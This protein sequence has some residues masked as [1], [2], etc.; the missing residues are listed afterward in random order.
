VG[1][2]QDGIVEISGAGTVRAADEAALLR[3]QA[4]AGR[5]RVLPAPSECV[6]L[7]SET[8]RACLLSGE[9]RSPGTFCD[10]LSFLGQMGW[11]GELVLEERGA[12]RSLYF[13]EGTVVAARST[14]LSE[15]LGEVLYRYGVLS[16]EQVTQCG[17]AVVEGVTRFGEAAVKLGCATRETLFGAMGRQTEEIFYGA[18]RTSEGMFFFLDGFEDADL[19]ARQRLDVAGIIREGIRRMHET[20]YFRARIPTSKHV[21][22]RIAGR[23][24]AADPMRLYA[25]IDDKR[26]VEEL[27][28]AIGAGDF[29][30][31]RALFQLVQSGCIVIKPPQLATRDVIAVY[32]RAIALI[33]RELDALDDG[34]SVRAELAKFVRES[35]VYELLFEGAGPADDGTL[36][37]SRVATNVAGAA[38]AENRLATWLYEYASYALFVARP[39]MQRIEQASGG[40][41]PR[42][43]ARVTAILE[44]IAPPAEPP[45][46]SRGG[47]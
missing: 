47:P 18:M 9:I 23:A 34:D 38:D 1:A 10:V 3:L 12:S 7:R 6:I 24:P 43:S 20:R 17:E 5:Y 41:M 14:V 28:R 21:P 46:S 36:D 25:A 15:R 30:V 27:C 2:E 13:D 31:T 32:N 44:Q 11:R 45:P 8:H 39:R 22:A 19:A 26:T 42:L 16:R 40:A 29:E 35:H 4:R 37:V 33:L